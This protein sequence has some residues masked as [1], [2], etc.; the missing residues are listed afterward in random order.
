L[1]ILVGAAIL[2][3]PASARADLNIYLQEAGVNGGAITLVASA[4]DFTD[5]SKSLTYGDFTVKVFGASSDNGATL[6]DLLSSTTS[7]TNNATT[8]KT[9]HL[10]ASQN[11]YTLPAGSPLMVESA[12]GGS[13]NTGTLTLTNIFQAYADKNNN[14]LGRTDYTNGPQSATANGT[15]FQTGSASGL[16]TRTGDFS[17]TTQVN[18]TL[19]SG[20]K[21]NYS[22]HENVTAV[23][24]APGGVVLALTGLPVLGI[25]ACLLRRRKVF[26]PLQVC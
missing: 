2:G 18:F 24:P 4:P 11:N 15:S 3:A 25:G 21:A 16:F 1:A 17:L 7:V 10:Y 26:L 23:V 14:L 8:S 12:L 20:G 13:V 9:L 19:S 22:D 5:V 6:S